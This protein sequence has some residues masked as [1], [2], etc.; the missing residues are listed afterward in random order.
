[1]GAP[2]IKIAM[3]LFFLLALCVGGHFLK[4][5]LGMVFKILMLIVS[6][7]L[8][9]MILVPRLTGGMPVLARISLWV[10]GILQK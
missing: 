4:K 1:M 8:V 10:Q 7:A 2:V 5:K 6:L 3:Y 9:A